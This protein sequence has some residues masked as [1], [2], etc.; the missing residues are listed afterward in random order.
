MY[1]GEKTKDLLHPFSGPS[2][3][4]SKQ[5]NSVSHFQSMSIHC[6]LLHVYW[7]S[8]EQLTAE[9]KTGNQSHKLCLKKQGTKHYIKTVLDVIGNQTGKW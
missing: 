4:P 5:S 6:P 9:T 1:M 2:S 8:G 3:L 7:W